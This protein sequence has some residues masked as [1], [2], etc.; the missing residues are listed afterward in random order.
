MPLVT[1][2]HEV[3][4]IY[5]MARERGVCLANFCTANPYT[6]QAIL[7]AAYEFGREHGLERV[8]IIVSA[9]ANYSIES[10]LVAY[11]PLHDARIG[12]R[13]LIADVELLLSEDSPY[14]DLRAMLHLDHG[15]PDRDRELL[16]EILEKYATV[17]FDSSNFPFE[18]N[19]RRTSEFVEQHGHQVQIEG[20]VTEIVQAACNAHRD[21]LTTPEQAERFWRE[22]GVSLLV[23]NLGTEHRAT[24]PVA[25]Y[26]SHAA[27]A[28]S[29][30][31]GKRLVLHG[32]SSVPEAALGTLAED[33]IVKVNLWTT[34]ERTGG[35]AV[36]RFVLH[37]LGNILSADELAALRAEGWL[38]ERFFSDEYRDTVCEGSA[39]PK[40]SGLR[41]EHRRDVWQEAVVAQMKFYLA[42]FHYDS[43]K[44]E[45]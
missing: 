37:Q 7:R 1:D 10:Q 28:I 41:E 31:V 35:Q 19:I 36:T 45:A 14:A 30:R 11:T 21:E 42:A 24:A 22:T 16:P 39:G 8:P 27:R 38:G 12:A 29:A 44:G 3:E 40:L 18:E 4:A 25:R 34:F 26:D 17:M 2:P 23:P 13:A 33:G 43:I 5:A 9:T 32:S 15:Q 20:A 6:T